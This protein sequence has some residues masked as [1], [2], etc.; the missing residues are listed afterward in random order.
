MSRHFA[1]RGM[2]VIAA[3]VTL[4]VASGTAFATVPPVLVSHNPSPYATTGCE[5]LDNQPG[6]LS[7]LNSEVEPQVAV[8]PTNSSHLVG[9]MAA[10]PLVQWWRSRPGRRVLDQR[11]RQLDR[12]SPTVQRMLASLRLHKLRQRNLPGL[13]AGV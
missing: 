3:A 5:T 9:S 12:E 7:Y 1:G 11:R 13:S 6:S 4:L 2:A 10:G 8:D